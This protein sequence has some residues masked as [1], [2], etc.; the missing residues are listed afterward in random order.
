[1]K[2]KQTRVSTGGFLI[3]MALVPLIQNMHNSIVLY[4]F[5]RLGVVL[6]V[7][8][9]ANVLKERIKTKIQNRSRL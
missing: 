3:A 9:A 7:G 2:L 4:V 1:M 6:L 8:A 5:Q